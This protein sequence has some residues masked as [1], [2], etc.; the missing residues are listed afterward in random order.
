VRPDAARPSGAIA[1]YPADANSSASSDRPPSSTD[2]ASSAP[3]NVPCR[4]STGASGLGVP[5]GSATSPDAVVARFRAST[6]T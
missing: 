5:S 4:N 3:L 6:V 1:A 2:G